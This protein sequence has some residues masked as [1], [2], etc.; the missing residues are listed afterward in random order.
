[1]SEAVVSAQQA[2]GIMRAMA[3]AERSGILERTSEG[4]QKRKEEL[5]KLITAESGKP[6]T[7]AKSEV[8]RAVFTFKYAARAALK[9]SEGAVI[10]MS[11]APRGADYQGSYK[12]FPIGIIAAITPFNFPLNLVA[13]KVAPAIAAGNTIVLKPAPQTPLTSFLLGEILES[14]G[15]PAGALNVVPCENDIAEELVRNDAIAMLSFTGSAPVG[16]KLKSLAGRAKVALELGGNGTVIV[17]EVRDWESLITSL[18]YAGFNYAGQVCI[19]LQNILVQEVLYSEMVERM[20]TA[21]RQTRVGDPADETTLVGPM[22]SEAAA[23]KVE[24]W[25]ENVV[26]AGAVRHSG[27]YNPPNWILPTILTNVP[28]ESPV[29]SEEVFAPIVSIR[30]YIKFEEA[31]DLVNSGKYGL[32]TGLFTTDETK[33]QLA[34]EKIDVGGLI[35]N[36]TNNFRLDHM[37]YGGTK[38]SGFGREGLDYA[39]REMSEIKLLVEKAT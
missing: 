21:A 38:A 5:A 1:M 6:I 31:I 28:L 32:Q 17:D 39:I 18:N 4:I 24:S 8:D 7:Y 23:K 9:A 14:A 16:W 10:D 34:Y 2:F 12:Y 30:P 22:I 20:V 26:S 35:I 3:A 36:E 11:A 15:L 33:I 27:N 29:W 13:H 25:V 37:P 19:G